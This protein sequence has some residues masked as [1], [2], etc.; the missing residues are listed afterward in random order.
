MVQPQQA[1]KVVNVIV[2]PQGQCAPEIRPPLSANP[3]PFKMKPVG[4]QE[5]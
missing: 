4:L 2:D 1:P 3:S 5:R